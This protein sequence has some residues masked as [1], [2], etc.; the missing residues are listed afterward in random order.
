ML[1]KKGLL[2]GYY[3]MGENPMMSEPD[4]LHARHVM[5]S[6][7]FVLY[8][9]IFMNETGEYADVI[10]PAVSFAEK[11]G[12]FTNSDRRVQLV[13]PAIRPPGEARPDWDIIQ[14]LARGLKKNWAGTTLSV[15]SLRIRLR[16]GMKW[17]T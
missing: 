4:L 1:L 13:R 17:L 8:Q 9:D 2:K 12:T 7:E 3:V 14:D 10:L 15:S 16:S 11:D 6:L 5:E